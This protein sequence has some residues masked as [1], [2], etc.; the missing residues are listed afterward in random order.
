MATLRIFITAVVIAFGVQASIGQDVFTLQGVLVG[1]D[2]APLPDGTYQIGVAF[3]PSQTGTNAL[4]AFSPLSVQQQFGAFSAEL[5]ILQPCTD[6]LRSYP[7]GFFVG[8]R[9]I[10]EDELRPR[11]KVGAVPSALTARYAETSAGSVPIGTVVSYIGSI[12]SMP[13]NWLPCDG[14]ALSSLQY[15]GLFK[16]LGKQFGD[17]SRQAPDTASYDFNLPDFRGRVLIGTGENY[18]SSPLEARSSGDGDRANLSPNNLGA[19]PQFQSPPI[20]G[21]FVHIIVRAR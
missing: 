18:F 13:Q 10:G 14:R 7:G 17:G 2:G 11:M 16:V 19:G 3:Y 4:C 1:K 5:E 9:I 6:S 15:P 12:D 20:I 21:S 8:V